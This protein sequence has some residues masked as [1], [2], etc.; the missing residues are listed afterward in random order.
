MSTHD[1]IDIDDA[2]I[3][4]DASRVVFT[5]TPDWI[6][7]NPEINDGAFRTW[8]AIASFASNKNHRAFPSARK[9]MEIRGKGRRIIFE[10]IRQLEAAG[11][12]TRD[13]RYRPSGGRTSSHY[14]LAWD[15]SLSPVQKTAPGPRAVDRTDPNAENRA[16]PSAENRAPRTRTTNEPDPLPPQTS[17]STETSNKNDQQGAAA[18][19]T[20]RIRKQGRRQDGTNPR[21]VKAEVSKDQQM[22]QWARTM[23]DALNHD[24]FVEHVES[25]I[26]SAKITAEQGRVAI[27]ESEQL[28]GIGQPAVPS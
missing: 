17:V 21:A 12:L 24:E 25:E 1:S 27:K 5:Q 19:R 4:W 16:A 28:S 7:T 10:H 6:L 3:S 14:T 18:P 15:H 13:A 26:R 23:H 8:M 20:P 9:L 11:L 22:R 2:T